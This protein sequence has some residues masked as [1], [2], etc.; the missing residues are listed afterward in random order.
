MK[1]TG[2]NSTKSQ[3]YDLVKIFLSNNDCPIKEIKC[4]TLPGIMKYNV[5]KSAYD[6]F[7]LECIDLSNFADPLQAIVSHGEGLGIILGPGTIRDISVKSPSFYKSYLIDHTYFGPAISG[8]LPSSHQTSSYKADIDFFTESSYADS[9]YFYDEAHIDAKIKLL[10]DLSFLS[11]KEMLG[12]KANE[13]HHSDKIC[14]EN[15]KREVEYD[16]IKKRYTVALPFKNNKKLLPNNEWIALKRTQILQRA[17]MN[18]KNYG[19]AYAAQIQNLLVADFIEEV[20]PYTEVGNIIHYLPHRGI[21]KKDNKTTSLRIVM[22]AS[23]KANASSLSLNDC[24]YTGPNLIVSMCFL[25]LKFRRERYGCTADIEKAFLNLLIRI[26]DRD[27]LRFFFPQDIF[28]PCSPMKIYRYKVVMFGASCSPFLL[29]AVIEIHLERHVYDRVLQESLKSIFIDNLLASKKT[30][31]ELLNF[32]HKAR[33][34]YQDMG[35]NLRQ[36]ASNS[37]LLVRTAKADGVWD[38]SKLVKVLGQLWDP[39]LDE[40]SYKLELNLYNIISKR[41]ILGTGNQVMDTFGFLLPVE[42]GFRMFVQKLW[43]KE[44]GWDYIVTDPVL[45]NKWEIIQSDLQL[46]LTAKFPRTMETFENVELHIF[47]DASLKAYGTVVYFVIPANK[48]N[49][50]GITQ[51]RLARGKAVSPR[52]CPTTDTIPKLELMGLVMSANTAVNIITAYSDLRFKRKILWSDST[53]ALHQ[54]SSPFNKTNFVQN[55][56]VNIREL[57]PGFEIRYVKSLENPADFITKPIRAKQLLTSKLWWQGPSWL[58]HKNKWDI[59]NPFSLFPDSSRNPVSDW[60]IDPIV[61]EEEINTMYGTIVSNVPIEATRSPD[62]YYWNFSSY[63]KCINFFSGLNL[64]YKFLKTLVITVPYIITYNDKA[65]AERL[66]I[67]TMQ[68]QSFPSEIL[69]LGKGLSVQKEKFLQLKLYLDKYGIIRVH[70]RMNDKYFINANRPILFAYRHPLTILF[71]QNKHKCLNCG[72]V[73][74]TLSQIRK[75]IHCPKLRRQTREIINKCIICRRLL[76][77]PFKYPENPPLNDYRLRCSRPFSMC[78]LDYIGPFTLR[79]IQEKDNPNPSKDKKVWIVLFSCLVSRAVYLVLVSNRKTETFLRALRE[80]SAR[81]CEPRMIISDNEGAFEAA[82]KIL[83]RIAEKPQIISEFGRKNIVWKFLP[84]RA[85]W[86]GGVYERLV[87]IIKIELMKMQRSCK[88]DDSE[89]R[90]HLVEIEAIVNDRPL[91]Y[92]SDVASEP[93]V[94]TPNAII[95]GCISDTTL[96]TDINIDEAIAEMKQYQ[97][98]PESL[99]REKIKIK[100]QFWNK[101]KEEYTLALNISNYKKNKSVGKYSRLIPKVGSVVAIQNSETKLG[102]RLGIIVKLLESSDGI[103]RRAEVKTT[104]PSTNT[105]LDKNYRTEIR[106]KAINQLL[107]LELEVDNGCLDETIQNIVDQD[108]I[109]QNSDTNP[110]G[111]SPNLH[112]SINTIGESQEIETDTGEPCGIKNCLSPDVATIQWIQCDICNTWYHFKCV[113]LAYTKESDNLD[114]YCM[115]CMRP[116]MEEFYSESESSFQGFPSQES[117]DI[118]NSRK[119]GKLTFRETVNIEPIIKFAQKKVL[120]RASKKKCRENFKNLPS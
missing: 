110:M 30:E 89:W 97:N 82:N 99:Y 22:D 11:D 67:K 87:Q 105:P 54:C 102:G 56:V 71:I 118:A 52:K 74:Y 101:I 106:I 116:Q 43:H 78:G 60:S 36:W 3:S 75:E 73:S 47:S 113:G 38:D 76:S 18:D 90:S 64:I 114:F 34:I 17:F 117:R 100:T 62:S 108:M 26:M 95:H 96:A 21:I 45:I 77:R 79:N 6:T 48:Y 86:M 107:P 85:S 40:F 33:E 16:P 112:D 29:A 35:L 8:R 53:T 51:I 103:V 41:K 111:D 81:H 109:S 59:E 63:D 93:E 69:A 66:A 92:V 57:C 15:F 65:E 50:E 12:V 24:L 14:L 94:I 98:N 104:I 7:M 120:E 9:K 44:Y 68:K 28:D 19:L 2:I 46:A 39:K 55:R 4:Y 91:T 80:L 37:E 115:S 83:Q 88:F 49:P 61:K 70:G 31:I 5:D 23:C 42:M 27:A 1:V 20:L 84:S 32:Y 25:L 10:E 72:S 119:I 58:P 13:M